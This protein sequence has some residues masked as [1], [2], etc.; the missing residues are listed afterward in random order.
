MAP[1]PEGEE[2]RPSGRDVIGGGREEGE[3]REDLALTGLVTLQK[4]SLLRLHIFPT[5]T[6]RPRVKSQSVK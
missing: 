3:M 5:M 2:P 4:M 1:K 6:T